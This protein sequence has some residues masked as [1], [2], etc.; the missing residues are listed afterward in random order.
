MIHIFRENI[1]WAKVML[2]VTPVNLMELHEG[3]IS[4]NL[5]ENYSIT[6]NFSSKIINGEG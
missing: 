4:V 6:L 1:K 3:L 5:G 2:G